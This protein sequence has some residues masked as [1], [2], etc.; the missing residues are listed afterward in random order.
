MS[1]RETFGEI[2]PEDITT[3]KHL[4]TFSPDSGDQLVR[5]WEEAALESSDEPPYEAIVPS[6]EYLACNR[7]RTSK[8]IDKRL[9][10]GKEPRRG[11]RRVIKR[12]D[13][14]Y[15]EYVGEVEASNDKIYQ[16]W[17]DDINSMLGEAW[18]LHTAAENAEG[19]STILEQ[20]EAW[21]GGLHSTSALGMGLLALG[22]ETA[23]KGILIDT[24]ANDGKHLHDL[25]DAYIYTKDKDYRTNYIINCS[26]SPYMLARL[27]LAEQAWEE[28][29]DITLLH[30]VQHF[31]ARIA[32][33][34]VL[35]NTLPDDSPHK[36]HVIEVLRN[37]TQQ[38]NPPRKKYVTVK[39]RASKSISEDGIF[40][41]V[42][43]LLDATMG[44]VPK[45]LTPD[46]SNF[47]ERVVPEIAIVAPL[48]R[49]NSGYEELGFGAVPN[50]Q[51]D[52]VRTYALRSAWGDKTAGPHLLK[53][54][55]GIKGGGALVY[56][57]VLRD[58]GPAVASQYLPNLSAEWRR[59]S[60]YH[61]LL[62]KLI[63][64]H[65]ASETPAVPSAIDNYGPLQML[66]KEI[67]ELAATTTSRGALTHRE[68][69]ELVEVNVD[70]LIGMTDLHSS[71]P[72]DIADLIRTIKTIDD[73]KVQTKLLEALA[74]SLKQ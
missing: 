58:H 5:I 70:A 35:A 55:E 1:S 43:T 61:T 57:N 48:L 68:E 72:Q 3:R 31:G 46:Y 24:N 52:A 20:A 73:I 53:G 30:A 11:Q 8:R 21:Q 62:H 9:E 40:G 69:T 45:E 32:M 10:S 7:P 16:S 74:E 28:E 51:K 66:Y 22:D 14:Y 41:A 65:K 33:A 56:R 36:E 18:V 38:L 27:V 6:D 54:G 50:N 29:P 64:G 25:L 19:Q 47:L 37:A 63:S 60:A 42:D 26:Q 71:R 2:P 44:G 49:P 12:Y 15:D 39:D 23:A 67:D 59:Y 13:R 4:A 34:A 17:R